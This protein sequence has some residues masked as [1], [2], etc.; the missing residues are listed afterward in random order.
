MFEKCKQSLPVVQRIAETTTDDEV[1]LFEAL[2]LNEELQ[3][4]I[5][6]YEEMEA[7]LTSGS[8]P[9]ENPHGAESDL[10]IVQTPHGAESDLPI[11]QTP[12]SDLPILLTPHT[13]ESDLPVF[14]T[15]RE[16]EM[17]DS[18]SEEKQSS[19]G[20]QKLDFQ[21]KEHDT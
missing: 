15:R 3:Q 5:S 9:P 13:A 21:K 19:S 10:L 1:M 4:I 8:V 7:A 6:K 17:T 18:P 14:D 20:T 16:T 2:H 11:F 12:H